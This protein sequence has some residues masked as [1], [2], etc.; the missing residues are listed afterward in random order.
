VKESPRARVAA[1]LQAIVQC[2][3]LRKLNEK[4][5][6]GSEYFVEK[7]IIAVRRVEFDTDRISYITTR[8]LVCYY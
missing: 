7:F 2:I 8:F 1:N 3:F 5:E 6:S 4:R